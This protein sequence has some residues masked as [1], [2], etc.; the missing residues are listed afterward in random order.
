[1]ATAYVKSSSAGRQFRKLV[2]GRW[3]V[4]SFETAPVAPAAAL[5]P[6]AGDAPRRLAHAVRYPACPAL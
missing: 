6:F 1:M 4:T 3:M 5:R 2:N